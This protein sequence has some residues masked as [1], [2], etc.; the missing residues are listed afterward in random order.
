MGSGECS[1]YLGL[2]VRSVW[3][4]ADANYMNPSNKFSKYIQRRGSD[5][6]DPNGMYDFI[7]HGSPNM[8]T[9]YING[10]D[11]H[12]NHR[13][14]ANLLRHRQDYNGQ[15]IRMF[16]CY[17][18][19]L[20]DGFAQNLANKLNTTVIGANNIIWCNPNGVY[21]VAAAQK[22]DKDKPDLHR[23]GKFISF[24]PKKK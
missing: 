5:D 18:G 12:V 10:R 19:S 17:V 9:L 16:S 15:P 22:S 8:V 2:D 13:D 7:A 21:Y 24:H 3:A 20:P 6:I 11:V 1:L 4:C 14:V 23:M